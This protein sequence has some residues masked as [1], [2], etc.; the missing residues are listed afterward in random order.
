MNSFI[1]E[2][3]ALPYLPEEHIR[4]SF[5]RL[6]ERAQIAAP[7][8]QELISYTRTTWID[9]SL[10]SPD[11]WSVFNR[12]VRTNNDTE[13]WHRRL[14]ARTRPNQ[15]MYT[16]INTLYK[17]AQLVPVQVR[18]VKDR[19]LKKYQRKVFKNIQGRLFRLWEQYEN[20]E[21]KTSELLSACSHLSAPN[22]H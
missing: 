12:S 18:L 15:Q 2:L 8:V 11:T 16:L 5:E 1:R 20:R 6:E 14:N 10:W 4:A 13:G 19:K 3:L 21:I 17:E 9:S 7:A 22:L